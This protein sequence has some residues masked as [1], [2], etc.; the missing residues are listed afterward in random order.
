MV[1]GQTEPAVKD[2]EEA[3]SQEPDRLEWF[4]PLAEYYGAEGNWD[5]IIRLYDRA[6]ELRPDDAE[7][8]FYR[9]GTYRMKGDMIRAEEDRRAA[10]SL[11]HPRACSI[12]TRR[13]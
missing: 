6:L 13:P 8:L 10:C 5:A 4:G 9:A 3:L 7:A 11:G 1:S 12:G 2:L